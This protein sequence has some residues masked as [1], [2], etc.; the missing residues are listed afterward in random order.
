MPQRGGSLQDSL[1]S[2]G[3]WQPTD[4][5]R[6]VDQIA[7]ALTTAHRLLQPGGYVY[8]DTSNFVYYNA[9]NPY[10][11]YIFSPETLEALLSECGFT[12]VDRE[13]EPAPAEVVAPP[14]PYLTFMARPGTSRFVR[15]HRSV[16]E[17]VAE[18]QLGLQK[19]RAL[20]ASSG[21]V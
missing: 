20:K 9:V 21:A 15:R 11:P 4:V 12:V 16:E 17:I 10:H 2:K 6:L 18:Q 14:N 8:I 19:T 3:A 1:E 7:G 13:H 5:V